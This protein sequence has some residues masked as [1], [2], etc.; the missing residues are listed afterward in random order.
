M[1]VELPVEKAMNSSGGAPGRRLAAGRFRVRRLWG[2]ALLLS[3]SCVPVQSDPGGTPRP[4]DRVDPAITRGASTTSAEATVARRV[5]EGEA[6]LRQRN[7][8][9]ARELAT[10]II[11]NFSATRGSAA[12]LW[13]RA[14]AGAALDAPADANADAMRFLA[15]LPSSDGRRPE[16]AWFAAERA[17]EV[18]DA[19]AA[20]RALG[21]LSSDELD[22][23]DGD[24]LSLARASVSGVST[25]TLSAL[26]EEL[27]PTPIADLVRL[28]SAVGLYFRGEVA[29]ASAIA[30]DLLTRPLESS[31]RDIA[32]SLISGT[33][34]SVLGS[35]VALGA[36]LPRSGSPAL[37]EYSDAIEEGIRVALD[38]RARDRR[39]PV[40]LE[41]RDDGGDPSRSSQA[42]QELEQAGALG[43]VGPLLDAQLEAAARVRSSGLPLISPTSESVPGGSGVYSL[44][45]ADPGAA[46]A[47]AEYAAQEGWTRIAIV[48]PRSPIG[49]AEAQVFQQAFADASRSGFVDAREF[50]YESGVT[51]FRDQLMGA[52]DFGA[53]AVVFPVPE[54]DV[55]LIAPQVSFFALDSLGVR[56][57][58][59]GAWASPDVLERVDARHLD[60]VIVASARNPEGESEAYRRF[61]ES[62]EAVV[63]KTLRSPVP[64]FGYDAT[65][66]LLEALDRGAR[67]PRDLQAQLRNIDRYEGAT[68]TLSV[69]DGQ[70]VRLHQLYEISGGELRYLGRNLR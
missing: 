68:G 3:V 66:L 44:G 13:V 11:D 43:V 22:R 23:V 55:E 29:Q 2:V 34:E 20:L 52:V 39:R 48:Y 25:D 35:D 19:A 7:P 58:G 4:T 18:D 67:S 36:I 38:S 61:V 31:D 32:E 27:G 45:A 65:M 37:R 40:R 70:V 17:Q 62:Y 16:V 63:R 28:E 56:V 53:E 46:Q 10:D 42:L 69:Q 51:F 5:A 49:A 8:E 30:R 57:M 24:P 9:R 64:A 1:R 33:A 60:G 47:L 6:A 12:G 26:S 59:T 14:R 21:V 41:L 50:T 15:L 54:S